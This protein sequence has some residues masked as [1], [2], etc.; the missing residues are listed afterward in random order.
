MLVLE[1]VYGVMLWLILFMFKN[2][3]N[4]GLV[5][6]GGL[7]EEEKGRVEVVYVGGMIRND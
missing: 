4:V 5:C 7:E 6:V 1:G 3:F 2:K